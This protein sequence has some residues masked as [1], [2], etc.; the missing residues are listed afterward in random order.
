MWMPMRVTEG[1][2]PRLPVPCPIRKRC[3]ALATIRAAGPSAY[4]RLRRSAPIDVDQSMEKLCRSVPL[5]SGEAMV[6][7]KFTPNLAV[8][9]GRE[10]VH[11]GAVVW[12]HS[13]KLRG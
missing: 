9:N 8:A 1:Q 4:L 13:K 2:V 6:C 5:A 7:P 3:P 11:H 10:A 12:C